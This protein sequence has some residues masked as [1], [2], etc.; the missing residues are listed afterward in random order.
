LLQREVPVQRAQTKGGEL[1]NNNC[2]GSGPHI[3]GEVRVLPTSPGS[4][5]ILCK[6]CFAH[7]LAWRSERNKELAADSRFDLPNWDTLKIYA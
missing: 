3:P 1:L 4:N 2:D 7:E 6:L 5:A